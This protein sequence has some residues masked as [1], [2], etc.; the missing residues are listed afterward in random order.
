MKSKSSWVTAN[1][2]C[3]GIDERQNVPWNMVKWHSTST[4]LYSYSTSQLVQF[5]GFEAEYE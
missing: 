3:R 2:T 5:R 4:V 1:T